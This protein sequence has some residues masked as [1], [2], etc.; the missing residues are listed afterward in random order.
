[1]EFQ[2]GSKIFLPASR[3]S[4][5][6]FDIAFILIPKAHEP[7]TSVVYFAATSRKSTGSRCAASSSRYFSKWWPHSRI[8]L[9]ISFNFFDVNIGDSFDLNGRHLFGSRLKRCCDNGSTCEQNLSCNWNFQFFY[10]INHFWEIDMYIYID[11][12]NFF[13]FRLRSNLYLFMNVKS[14]ICEFRKIPDQYILD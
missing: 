1:M 9:N 4:L 6:S 12:Y 11:L 3:N 2:V 13:L 8:R 14:S 5:S 10:I 7:I